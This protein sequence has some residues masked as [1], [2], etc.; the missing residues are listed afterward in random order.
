MI[1]DYA[2]YIGTYH[3]DKLTQAAF[4]KNVIRAEKEMKKYISI[5]DNPTDDYK[6]CCCSLTEIINDNQNVENIR[7]KGL[8]NESVQGYS[9]SY[10]NASETKFSAKKRIIDEIN[11]WIDGANIHRGVG[12]DV[13]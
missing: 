11:F 7:F 6:M 10:E 2:Y 8:K 5:P 9:V 1:A 12:R 4:E 13:Y 3:G